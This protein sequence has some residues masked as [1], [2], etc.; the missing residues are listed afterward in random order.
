MNPIK[1][2]QT[3]F[4]KFFMPIFCCA[5]TRTDPMFLLSRTAD[6]DSFHSY[7]GFTHIVK[8][9][10]YKINCWRHHSKC[11]STSSLLHLLAAFLVLVVRRWPSVAIR[12]WSPFLP[13]SCECLVSCVPRS[14]S[15]L[16]LTRR[17][18]SSGALLDS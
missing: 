14:V 17:H 13:L 16:C 3:D 18:R 12:G 9:F 1:L 8:S 5:P 2:F 11:T 15:L 7:A 10:T 6:A 4:L